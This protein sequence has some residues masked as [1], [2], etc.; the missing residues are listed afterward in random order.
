MRVNLISYRYYYNFVDF[1]SKYNLLLKKLK[2]HNFKIFEYRF[3]EMDLSDI[4]LNTEKSINPKYL[5][6]SAYVMGLSNVYLNK[7]HVSKNINIFLNDTFFRKWPISKI[8]NK[9]ISMID[10]K[11]NDV[12]FPIGIGQIEDGNFS[13]SKKYNCKIMATHFFLLNDSASRYILEIN[14]KLKKKDIEQNEQFNLQTYL[15]LLSNSHLSIKN[16]IDSNIFI[17]KRYS[18]YFEFMLSNY[19]FNNGIGYDIFN[20]I[21]SKLGYKIKNIFL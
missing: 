1:Q 21:T 13:F 2:I 18:M 20:S 11:L 9:M 17:K 14:E 7:N 8:I 16:R 10:T 19:I 4:D 6:F 15:T 12:S 5:D 3:A